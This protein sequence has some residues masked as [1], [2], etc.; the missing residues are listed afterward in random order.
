[1][2]LL[3]ADDHQIFRKAFIN[4]LKTTLGPNL[5]YVE[6][7]NGKEALKELESSKVD[8]V[9]LDVSMPEMNGIEAYKYIK[10]IYP[11]VP[12]IVLTQYDDGVLIYHFFKMGVQ[13]FFTENA[14]LDEIH[15]AIDCAVK[16]E[17]Y[18]PKEIQILIEKV[19]KGNKLPQK[20]ELTAQEKRLFDLLCQGYTSKEIALKMNLTVNTVDTYRERLLEKT[21][22]SNVAQ[23]ISFGFKIGV[24]N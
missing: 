18:F 24:L 12:V 17:R 5:E 2:R 11:N 6:A 13:S 14:G 20:V 19:A 1:M 7:S 21:V 23:L 10:E 9:I 3:I 4:L 16:G 22:T 8:I 15:A